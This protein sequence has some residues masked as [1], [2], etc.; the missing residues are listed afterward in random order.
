MEHPGDRLYAYV[1]GALP[2]QEA[3]EVE[4]HVRECAD[5]RRELEDARTLTE[6][7]VNRPTTRVGDC[8]NI[9]ALVGFVLGRTAPRQSRQVEA[10]LLRCPTCRES[11]GRLEAQHAAGSLQPR[12][13][14]YEYLA[15][16][17]GPLTEAGIP[18]E[19][20]LSG[21][22]ATTIGLMGT[23]GL[24]LVAPVQTKR[25]AADS[26]AGFESCELTAE[27]GALKA[28]VEQFGEMLRVR[29]ESAARD[30]RR[31]LAVVVFQEGSTARMSVP[32]AVERGEGFGK[33]PASAPGFRRPEREPYTVRVSF[34]RPPELVKALI[35]YGVL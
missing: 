15:D 28:Q 7:P 8:P 12:D 30:L 2:E 19:A 18:G 14:A 4:S 11:A 16:V 32:A 23:V 1:I 13:M 29:L 31:G 10:H 26:E 35:T 20:L 5:C 33:L 34:V 6:G 17:M 3:A 22:D 25:L 27:D 21:M 9:A 24:S